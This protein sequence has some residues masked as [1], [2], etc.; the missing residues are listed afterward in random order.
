MA[1]PP[2]V[3]ITFSGSPG[4]L[5]NVRLLPTFLARSDI[6]LFIE[7][8][9]PGAGAERSPII[10]VTAVYPQ[11]VTAVMRPECVSDPEVIVK[12]LPVMVSVASIAA[13]FPCLTFP[14]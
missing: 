8:A 11:V 10:T 13:S 9:D 5:V 7:P 14:L 6:A 1:P 4:T 3:N 12:L 2:L